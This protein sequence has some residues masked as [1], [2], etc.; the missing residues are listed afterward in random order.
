MSEISGYREK[1]YIEVNETSH[2]LDLD[3]YVAMDEPEEIYEEVDIE[4]RN[5]IADNSHWQNNNCKTRMDTS[6][7]KTSWTCSNWKFSVL[8]YYLALCLQL[9]PLLFWL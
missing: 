5:Q 7:S 8:K 9:L 4:I 6:A 3:D 1:K 2:D